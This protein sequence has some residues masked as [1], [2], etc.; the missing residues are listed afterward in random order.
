MARLAYL[1][2]I[3]EVLNNFDI[4]FQGTNG[5][6][7]EYI[8][9]LALW[10]KNVKNKKYAMFKLLTSVEDKPNDEFLE[11][12]V[13]PLFATKKG[14]DALLSRRYILRLLHQPILC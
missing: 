7:P 2:D 3:F 6:L 11:E 8:S 14:V 9:N 12:I 4:S 13:C 1:S 10:I 5:T